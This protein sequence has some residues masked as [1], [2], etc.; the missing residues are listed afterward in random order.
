MAKSN[1][2]S[3]AGRYREI[4]NAKI[5]RDYFI[6]DSFECGIVLTG[7][8]V[9][10]LRQG[11]AQITDAFARVERG[12]VTLYHAHIDEYSFGNFANHNPKRPRRLLLHKREILKIESQLQPGRRTLVPRR[13]YFKGGL[14][15]LELCVCMGK[16]QYDKREDLKQKVDRREMDRALKSQ[17]LR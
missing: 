6:E 10:S 16:K 12:Q 2:K 4:R 7:T 14:I 9:K 17:G 1:S 3:G 5:G 8:E 15:K 13:I 11:N